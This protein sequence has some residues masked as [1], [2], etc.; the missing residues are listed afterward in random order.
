MPKTDRADLLNPSVPSGELGR[1]YGAFT[2]KGEKFSVGDAALLFP[3]AY[4]SPR[5]TLKDVVA[6]L[7]P[8]KKRIYTEHFRHKNGKCSK[9]SN[10]KTP[11]PLRICVIEAIWRR[12]GKEDVLLQVRKLYRPEEADISQRFALASDLNRVLWTS[13]RATVN[14]NLVTSKC[15]LVPLALLDG[16]EKEWCEGGRNRFYISDFYSIQDKAVQA[17]PGEVLN[18]YRDRSRFTDGALPT[19]SRQP[20]RTLDVFAGCG[21]LSEGLEQSGVS[22]CEWAIEFFEPA[23]EAF[24]LNHPSATVLTQDCNDVLKDVIAGRTKSRNGDKLPAKGEVELLVGGPPCQGFSLMNSFSEREYSQF[25]NSSVASYLSYCDFYRPDFFV[26]ENVRNFTAFQKSLV[27]KL[28]LRSL[29]KMGYQ[30]GFGVLQAGHFGVPQTRHRVFILAAAPDQKLPKFPEARHVFAK[31]DL[32]VFVDERKF[33]SAKPSSETAALRTITVRDAISDLPFIGNG[34]SKEKLKYL[35][36]PVSHYQRLMRRDAVLRDHICRLMPPLF[37]K[38]IEHIVAPGCDWRDLPNIVEKLSDGTKT[39][40]LRYRYKLEDG[41]PGV[42]ICQ[43]GNH[44]CLPEDKQKNTLIPW[45]LAHT[46]SRNNQWAGNFGRIHWDGFF[47]TVVTVPEPTRKQGRVIHPQQHRVVSV[48]EC[49]R[50]QGFRDS[51]CFAGSLADKH[52]EIGNAVPPCL[53][54]AIG[55]EIGQALAAKEKVVPSM[56]RSPGL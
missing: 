28:T 18:K 52:K 15:H 36:D 1:S 33:R 55:Q 12:R 4:A 37:E 46:A 2:Y 51:Y 20:L 3:I 17:L 34:A 14:A 48:R 31:E 26:F 53:A 54:K 41:T 50:A 38:R 23:A 7:P 56:T 6:Q 9:G 49:A 16:K 40:K 25:K 32:S 29:V 24:K 21:G 13:E 11:D 35:K 19:F 10:E 30:C 22:R 44:A 43:T 45:S 5:N 27:L 8:K 39:K 47:C 42:C